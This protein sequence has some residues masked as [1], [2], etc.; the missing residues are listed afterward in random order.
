MASPSSDSAVFDAYARY[1]DLLYR[2]KDYAAEA[3][4][5]QAR[6]AAHGLAGTKILELGCG[7]GRH[8]FELH[9]LGY[10]VTGVDVSETMVAQAQARLSGIE[11]A[12]VQAP[13][14]QTGDIRT[15][16]LAR[17]F[18]AVLSLF[19]VF[20][21]QTSTADLR[22]AVE[23]AAQHL[24]RNGLFLFDFWYG[25]AVLRDLPAVR[26]KRFQDE[27]LK[28][29]R[30]AEPEFSPN[31]NRVAVNYQVLLQDLSTGALG[32]IRETHNMRYLFLPEIEALLKEQ[33]LIVIDSGAWLEDRPLGID[34]WYGWVLARYGSR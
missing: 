10:E 20:S 28:V 17:Q 24:R 8:A 12:A 14:F 18:D 5:V 13:S 22:A 1:Y 23:T 7:T 21:Y 32:E 6:L 16:R 33:S 9:K 4:F 15:V 27:N 3:R 26:V 29:T 19:H 25:P 2:D 11:A 31:E 30:I 34:T